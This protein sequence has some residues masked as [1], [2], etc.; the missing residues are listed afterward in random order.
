MG[1]PPECPTRPL[2]LVGYKAKY[3]LEFKEF[4]PLDVTGPVTK[5]ALTDGD[6]D[7]ALLLSSDVPQGTVILEDDKGLQPAENLIPVIRT[8]KVTDEIRD[9]LNAV[10]EKLTLE[11]LVEL[12]QE[13]ASDEKP[14][15]ADL[16]EAWVEEY[17]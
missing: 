8:D 6:I 10:S 3:G 15:P 13:A 5:K 11:E 16:A 12:N 2:C 7:V 14:D 1:G 4:K 9:I 17:L